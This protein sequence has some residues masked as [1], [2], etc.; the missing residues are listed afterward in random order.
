[1]EP[2]VERGAR[3]QDGQAAVEYGLIIAGLAVVVIAAMLF[4]AGGVDTLFRRA[5]N[6][7]GPFQPP[8]AACEA[9]YPNVCVP[10]APPD[11]DCADRRRAA[12]PCP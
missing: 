12:Y 9:S 4:L 6:S 10:P 1:V 5:S 2:V 3:R 7:T 11:L 8:V